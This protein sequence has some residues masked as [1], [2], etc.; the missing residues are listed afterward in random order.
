M[1]RK[2]DHLRPIRLH[3]TEVKQETEV[4]YLGVTVD[5]KLRLKIVRREHISESYMSFDDL[6]VNCK[7]EIGMQPDNSTLHHCNGLG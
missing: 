4:K 1:E 7:E 5:R 6:Q 2:L 3:G